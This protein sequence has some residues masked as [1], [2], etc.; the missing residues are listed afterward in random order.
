MG[1]NGTFA[2]KKGPMV[3]CVGYVRTAMFRLWAALAVLSFVGK[4]SADVLSRE[5]GHEK[6][7]AAWNAENIPEEGWS[8]KSPMLSGFWIFLRPSRLTQIASNSIK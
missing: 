3:A 1:H 6:D 5:E 8:K 4:R 2:A 7:T